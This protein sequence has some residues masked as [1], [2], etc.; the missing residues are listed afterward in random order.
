MDHEYKFSFCVVTC[1]QPIELE[2]LL[3]SLI[4]QDLESVEIII[5]DDSKDNKSKL[6][7]DKYLHKMDIQYYHLKPN[8]VDVAVQYVVKKA[9]GEYLLLINTDMVFK[10]NVIKKAL[11]WVKDHP[12]VGAYSCKLLNT[13]LTVQATGGYFPTLFRV[14][15]WQ[16]FIDDLPFIRSLIKP[17]HPH[18]PHFS[19]IDRFKGKRNKKIAPKSSFYNKPQSPDWVT[20]A[21]TIIPRKLFESLD[22]F[23]ENIWMYAEELELCYR[24]KAKGFKVAYQPKP[25]IIHLA[26]ASS[27][28]S[29]LGI[30][31]ETKNLIYFFKKHKP[32]WQLPVVKL[33]FI[34]GSILRFII[35]GIIGK[36]ET[37]R[38][39]YPEAI[40]LAI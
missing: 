7:V 19:I 16:F 40:K 25:S 32:T 27:G 14:F 22:G 21:F 13:D 35:F 4:F 38:K 37:A 15:A 36:N 23:D 18:E 20:G 10:T 8:G 11:D 5:R 29:R 2:R 34:L 17:I 33:F 39:A 30:T 6:V 28:G 31:Q 24:I 26:G 12:E 3:N 1:N 9:K